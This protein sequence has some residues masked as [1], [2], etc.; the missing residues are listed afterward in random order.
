MYA[1]THQL[2]SQVVFVRSITKESHHVNRKS[3]L[4]CPTKARV[5]RRASSRADSKLD[6]KLTAQGT[7]RT[8]EGTNQATVRGGYS[9]C[10]LGA[11]KLLP[12][13]KDRYAGRCLDRGQR[14]HR[15]S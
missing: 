15:H 8:D 6:L 2:K 10:F 12:R 3:S 13:A 4:P 1:V 11:I 5:A 9:A 7:Q 14:G